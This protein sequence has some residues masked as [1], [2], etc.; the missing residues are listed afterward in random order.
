M[1][2]EHNFE[3]NN[4][5]YFSGEITHVLGWEEIGKMRKYGVVIKVL[6]SWKEE[7]QKPL[8]IEFTWF[9]KA[10]KAAKFIESLP[11]AIGREIGVAVRFSSREWKGRWYTTCEGLEINGSGGIRDANKKIADDEARK[12]I[13]R[14]F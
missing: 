10:E 5:R 12:K 13:N 2:T 14:G 11:N 1:V 4:I 7:Q 9:E 8:H 6:D 3:S